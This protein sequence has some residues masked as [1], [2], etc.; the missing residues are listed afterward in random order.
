MSYA[1]VKAYP[2]MKS[3]VF[4][5]PAVV[6]VADHFRPSIEEC[7]YRDNVTFIAGDFFKD[8]LPQADLYSF[9]SIFHDWDIDRINFLLKKV[10]NSLPAGKLLFKPI[11]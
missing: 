7:P 4:D 6:D 2:K 10:Y 3:T 9:V 1:A 5:L 8:D 11:T